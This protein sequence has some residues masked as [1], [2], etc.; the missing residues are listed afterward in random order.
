M[1]DDYVTLSDLTSSLSNPQ[2]SEQYAKLFLKAVREGKI[3]AAQLTEQFELPKQFTRRDQ[4][5]TLYRK[6][7][8]NY[9]AEKS[10]DFDQWHLE[11]VRQ[12][13]GQQRGKTPIT[14]QAVEKGEVDFQQLASQTRQ[15]LNEK[16]ER[17]HR[18]GKNRHQQ[19]PQLS[20]PGSSN[21]D[22][23]LQYG[24][25]PAQALPVPSQPSAMHV[26]T[27]SVTPKGKDGDTKR[28]S[29][30]R[31]ATKKSLPRTSVATK[32]VAGK[33]KTGT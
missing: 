21:P 33:E 4:E 20:A 23:Y 1:T 12:L 27:H 22:T 15:Q 28:Q 26:K 29:S 25:A 32:R 13:R 18:L 30:G 2:T 31:T 17:G 10:P 7:H 14:R 11:T 19:P 16:F 6:K 3:L 24:G 5:K 8:A 9:L